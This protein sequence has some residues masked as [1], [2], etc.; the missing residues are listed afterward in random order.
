MTITS[1]QIYQ[2]GDRAR[3]ASNTALVAA[4][5]SLHAAADALDLYEEGRDSYNYEALD[6]ALAQ[7]EAAVMSIR[8]YKRGRD[9]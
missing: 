7:A 9:A 4:R 8:A 1:E 6:I 2:V 3:A 5:A